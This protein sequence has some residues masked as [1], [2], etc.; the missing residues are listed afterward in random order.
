MAP[1]DSTLGIVPEPTSSVAAD[2]E[3]GRS[4]CNPWVLQDTDGRIPAKG[5]VQR[6]QPVVEHCYCEMTPRHVAE[7]SNDVVVGLQRHPVYIEVADE[8]CLLTRCRSD[9]TLSTTSAAV[10]DPHRQEHHD[11][12]GTSS[13]NSRHPRTNDTPPT[14]SSSSS[15]CRHD[16]SH[17]CRRKLRSGGSKE[18]LHCPED[19]E[20]K[21]QLQNG[22]TDAARA[23]V[24][25]CCSG[26]DKTVAKGRDE[27]QI[28]DD[29]HV[30]RN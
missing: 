22:P 8:N 23:E 19:G 14:S 26:D 27:K 18:L 29:A 11:H 13:K 9:D 21:R 7:H 15:N 4:E 5:Y 24:G 2:Q 6:H 1:A 12:C 30:G 10:C 20:V 17:D 25:R 28:T 3:D 16:K